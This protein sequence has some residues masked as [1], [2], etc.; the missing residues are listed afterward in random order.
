MEIIEELEVRR[1]PMPGAVGYIDYDGIMD[2]C[3]TI[4]TIT[5]K[6]KVCNLQAG[7]GI[8]ADS[9]PTYEFNESMNKMKALSVAAAGGGRVVVEE[10]WEIGEPRLGGE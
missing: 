2:T 6:G 7:G 5:M 4:R 8:V 9:D 3:I 10:I 1:V